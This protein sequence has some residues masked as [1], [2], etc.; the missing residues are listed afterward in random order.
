MALNEH[1]NARRTALLRA[2]RQAQNAEAMQNNQTGLKGSH[3]ALLVVK[4]AAGLHRRAVREHTS[5]ALKVSGIGSTGV[6]AGIGLDECGTNNAPTRSQATSVA[7]WVNQ[8]LKFAQRKGRTAPAVPLNQAA[9]SVCSFESVWRSHGSDG[10]AA[11]R[12]GSDKVDALQWP[13]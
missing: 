5:K 10:M 8:P 7:P 4:K 13:A 9:R 2:E 1:N 12:D 6:G 3:A 11:L